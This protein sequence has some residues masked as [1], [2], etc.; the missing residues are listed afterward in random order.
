MASH[1]S[2]YRLRIGKNAYRARNKKHQAIR[3]NNS[4]PSLATANKNDISGE[5]LVDL[6]IFGYDLKQLR[7]MKDFALSHGFEL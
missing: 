4:K 3:C 6:K 2:N 1:N 5:S 7:R